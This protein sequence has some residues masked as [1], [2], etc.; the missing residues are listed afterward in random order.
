MW[1]PFLN[2]FVLTMIDQPFR[3]QILMWFGG[4][5]GQPSSSITIAAA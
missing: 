3:S 4:H 2:W 5:F 1:F